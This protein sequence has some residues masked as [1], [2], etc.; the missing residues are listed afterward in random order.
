MGQLRV[1]ERVRSGDFALLKWPGEKNPADILAKAVNAG[2]IDCR[3]Q[4]VQSQWE[5]GRAACAPRLDGFSW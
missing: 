5:D 4:F 3:L 2:L 1:Q